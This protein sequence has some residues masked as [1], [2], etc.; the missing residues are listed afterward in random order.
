[1]TRTEKIK[2]KQLRSLK[3][4]RKRIEK[5]TEYYSTARCF[6]KTSIS[7][8]RKYKNGSAFICEMRY[9]SCEERGYCN[10]DC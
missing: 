5:D 3:H 10:G 9:E 6:D 8:G 7:F 1:M 4:I 2:K